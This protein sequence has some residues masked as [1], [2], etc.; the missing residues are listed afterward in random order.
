MLIYQPPKVPTSIPIIDLTPSLSGELD[1][2]DA[3]A[4]EIHKACR[5]MGF[6]YI[7]HH[8]VDQKLVDAPFE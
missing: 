6:F 5:E 7:S 2:I 8:G 3:A 1:K 4:R